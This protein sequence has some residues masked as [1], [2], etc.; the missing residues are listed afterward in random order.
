MLEGY[1]MKKFNEWYFPDHEEHLQKWMTTV[2]RRERGRLA[3]QFG[4]YELALALCSNRRTAVDIGSHVGLWAYYMAHDFARVECFEPMPEHIACWEANMKDIPP[5]TL[6]QYALGATDG[7]VAIVTRTSD[8]SGDT[9]V[10]SGPGG[11]KMATLDS[12]G[13]Q[14]V[15]FIKLDCEGYETFALR[16]GAETIKRCKPVI[17]VE[18]K[19]EMSKQYGLQP[20]SAVRYLETLGASVRGVTSGDYI[21]S[22]GS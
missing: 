20:L 13:L 7:L 4:K 14:D 5:A 18:Q 16:G 19:G 12:L 21:M 15:D 3:Y 17:I 11:F 22:W 1:Q 2:N 10:V 9:G 8:S 6:H